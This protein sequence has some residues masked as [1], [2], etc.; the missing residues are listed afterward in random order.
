M[1]AVAWWLDS[2]VRRNDG[3]DGVCLAR[4]AESQAAPGGYG[5]VQ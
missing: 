4:G 5:V 1:Q 2:G 3:G